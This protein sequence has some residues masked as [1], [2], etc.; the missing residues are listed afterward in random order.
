MKKV[1]TH[2]ENKAVPVR[3]HEVSEN[4]PWWVLAIILF[5]SAGCSILFAIEIYRA[6]WADIFEWMGNYRAECILLGT[7][8][9]CVIGGIM[10][11]RKS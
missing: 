1:I 4:Y 5:I 7:G 9:A 10:A 6:P 8:I 11:A 2:A 3:Q